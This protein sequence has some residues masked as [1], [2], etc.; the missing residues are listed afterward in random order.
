MAE[1]N[2][3]RSSVGKL[4]ETSFDYQKPISKLQQTVVSSNVSPTEL[5]ALSITGINGPVI[6]RGGVFAWHL[7]T[8]VGG[9]QFYTICL[10][11]V[12]IGKIGD[13]TKSRTYI[14]PA[15]AYKISFLK[16]GRSVIA[17]FPSR[18]ES[19]RSTNI[20]IRANETNTLNINY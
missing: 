8:H 18:S 15:G 19:V 17:L 13:L 10:N 2:L 7:A 9:Y 12:P 3:S 4:N 5:G 16:N 14:L 11:D 20:I 6:K 1:T